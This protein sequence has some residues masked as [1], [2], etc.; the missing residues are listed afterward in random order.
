[1]IAFLKGRDLSAS[2]VPHQKVPRKQKWRSHLKRCVC[3]RESS[4]AEM[5]R[6]IQLFNFIVF[7]M[8]VARINGGVK[9]L[10]VTLK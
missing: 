3:L 9:I 1:M 5:K 8:F 2:Q 6:G 7:K 4:E 10:G